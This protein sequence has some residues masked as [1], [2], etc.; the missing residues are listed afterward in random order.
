MSTKKTENIIDELNSIFI[1]TLSDLNI[2]LRLDTT[3]ADIEGWDS[4]RHIE[5]I[6][7][8]ET[9]YSIKFTTREIMSFEDIGSLVNLI[10]KKIDF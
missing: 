2:N 5:L 9:Y 1:D 6:I 3:A 10:K 4:L 8:I 7:N